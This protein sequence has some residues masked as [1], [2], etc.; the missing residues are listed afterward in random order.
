MLSKSIVIKLLFEKDDD[1]I[2]STEHAY[3]AF[4]VTI[5]HVFPSITAQASSHFGHLLKTVFPSVI[6]CVR[7]KD[8]IPHYS[9]ISMKPKDL[10]EQEIFPVLGKIKQLFEDCLC[11]GAVFFVRHAVFL[12]DL[13][14]PGK[15]SSSMTKV[16]D[17]VKKVMRVIDECLDSPTN[18]DTVTNTPISKPNLETDVIDVSDSESEI[19][20]SIAIESPATDNVPI[21]SLAI[22][23]VPIESPA[24]VWCVENGVL[25]LRTTDEVIPDTTASEQH[26]ESFNQHRETGPSQFPLHTSENIY[27]VGDLVLPPLPCPDPQPS[28]SLPLVTTPSQLDGS[29]HSSYDTNCIHNSTEVQNHTSHLPQQSMIS[30]PST[31]SSGVENGDVRFGETSYKGN[32]QNHENTNESEVNDNNSIDSGICSDNVC[33]S[34]ETNSKVKKRRETQRG[35][36]LPKMKAAKI[37]LY[38][39]SVQESIDVT[40]ST[41]YKHIKVTYCFAKFPSKMTLKKHLQVVHPK[42]IMKASR[43]FPVSR[44][45]IASKKSVAIYTC[46]MC[47]RYFSGVHGYKSHMLSVHSNRNLFSCKICN[48]LGFVRK[49]DLLMHRKTQH[50]KRPH[51]KSQ[52]VPVVLETEFSTSSENEYGNECSSDDTSNEDQQSI[53]TSDRPVKRKLFRSTGKTKKTALM[54][55]KEKKEKRESDDCT[56]M[57]IADT[58]P[59]TCKATADKVRQKTLF[60]PPESCYSLSINNLLP[61]VTLKKIKMKTNEVYIVNKKHNK[62]MEQTTKTAECSN[63]SKNCSSTCND[64]DNSNTTRG[65]EPWYMTRMKQNTGLDVYQEMFS[66]PYCSII[67]PDTAMYVTHC[68]LH[69]QDNPFQCRL[70]LV[71]CNDKYEFQKHRC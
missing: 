24:M 14:S 1:G 31:S 27:A 9:K 17:G 51:R 38:R 2:I 18:T 22:D 37:I 33:R 47:Q 29:T 61:S 46:V 6:R 62:A 11:D 26:N 13:I 64:A 48:K 59:S 35:K 25:V 40:K 58:K 15:D 67:F 49:Y 39:G 12:R 69:C 30:L 19:E 53:G 52:K 66:C 4:K 42:Q 36:I 63:T 43:P 57:K 45:L 8:R 56:E 16:S 54:R 32:N 68:S 71:Q 3:S 65:E 34:P 10:L 44:T 23:N 70:C 28:N 7:T 60:K 21:E 55:R 20:D 5:E 50:A 41:K